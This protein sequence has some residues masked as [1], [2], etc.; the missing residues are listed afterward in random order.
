M[1]RA[2]ALASATVASSSGLDGSDSSC[3]VVGALWSGGA[4]WLA[5]TSR[6]SSGMA[7]LSRSTSRLVAWADDWAPPARPPA[8]LTAAAAGPTEAFARSTTPGMSSALSETSCAEALPPYGEAA[9]AGA[10]VIAAVTSPAPVPRPTA[11]AART[12]RPRRRWRSPV[13]RGWSVGSTSCGL[14]LCPQARYQ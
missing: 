11:I 14:L 8:E 6:L 13:E 9:T 12:R 5:E 2:C 1:A 4:L 7:L 10:A 3:F